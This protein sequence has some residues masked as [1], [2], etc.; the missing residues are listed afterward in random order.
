MEGARATIANDPKVKMYEKRTERRCRHGSSPAKEI[1]NQ[2]AVHN[3]SR[4]TQMR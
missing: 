3:P 1:K 2:I 4:N